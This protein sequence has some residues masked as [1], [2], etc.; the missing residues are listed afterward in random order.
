MYVFSGNGKLGITAAKPAFNKKGEFEG[1][2]GVDLSLDSISQYLQKTKISQ[3]AV[4]YIMER[5]GNLIAS[6][7]DQKLYEDIN[8]TDKKRI[9]AENAQNVVIAQSFNELYSTLGSFANVP[10]DISYSTTINGVNYII[11]VFKYQDKYDLDWLI[12]TAIDKR[13]FMGGVYDVINQTVILGVLILVLVISMGFYIASKLAKPIAI[14]GTQAKDVAGGD[15]GA[16][17]DSKYAISSEF[18]TLITAFNS[19]SS[20]LK[21]YFTDLSTLNHNLEEKV[22]ERTQQVR[23][24]LNNADQGFLAFSGDMIILNEYSQ[25]CI[26]IFGYEIGGLDISK[27]LFKDKASRLTFVENLSSLV[28]DDD[29]L[30]IENILSLLQ[31]EFIIDYKIILA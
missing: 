4:T 7:T 8:A 25:K 26:E 6:S 20:Q 23:I 11:E 14:L 17:V 12:V 16:S 29:S 10:D 2:F 9:S 13:D 5:N 24:L 28:G 15:F 22:K 1:V 27:L 18:E 3:H 19:M 21:N 30:R 31:K